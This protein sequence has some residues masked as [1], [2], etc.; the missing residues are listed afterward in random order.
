[1]RGKIELLLGL[2]VQAC[3]DQA[4]LAP[5]EYVVAIPVEIRG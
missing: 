1:M 3:S 5:M 2:K 4:C